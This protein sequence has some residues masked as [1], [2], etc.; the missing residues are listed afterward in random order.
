MLSLSLL[1]LE[2]TLTRV[3]SVTMWYHFAFLSI[4]L[5]LLGGAVG[6]IWAYLARHRLGRGE[7]ILIAE[8]IEFACAFQ[9]RRFPAR[10]LANGTPAVLVEN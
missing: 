10:N 3:F 5:A 6:G 1:M 4:S 7:A 8:Y 2:V 9:G